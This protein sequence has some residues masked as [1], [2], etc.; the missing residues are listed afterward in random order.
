M[1]H[2][3]FGWLIPINRIWL[4]WVVIGTRTPR[5]CFPVMMFQSKVELP[6]IPRLQQ[7]GVRSGGGLQGVDIFNPMGHNLQSRG[8][9][10]MN[11]LGLAF[12]L[13]CKK[14][15]KSHLR[16]GTFIWLDEGQVIQPT[17]IPL[18]IAMSKLPTWSLFCFSWQ[19]FPVKYQ[20]IVH[21]PWQSTICKNML[22]CFDFCGISKL[23]SRSWCNENGNANAGFKAK[24]FCRVG[25]YHQETK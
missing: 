4:L 25:P 22:N 16:H 21:A 23:F 18:W 7:L 19:K 3:L 15:M 14:K 11:L 17:P 5:K 24:S 12:R 8:D 2:I 6:I 10:L 9:T 13:W 20:V 1:L